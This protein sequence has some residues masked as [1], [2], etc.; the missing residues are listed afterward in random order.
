MCG[1]EAYADASIGSLGIEFRKRVT[2]GVELA[3]K[4]TLLLFLDEPTS[5][6]DSQ[7]A[8]A[9]MAFLRNLANNGQAILCTIH[10][11]SAD[12]FQVFDRLLLLRK[13]GQTV[14]FGDLGHNA[15]TLIHYFEKNGAR[16][17]EPTENPA[18]FMLDVIGAGATATSEQDWHAIWKRSSEAVETQEEL[19]SIHKDGRSRPPVEA[20]IHS[21]FATPWVHQ[22]KELCFRD[23]R[24][25]WRS[26]TYLMAKL[27]LNIF[28]GLFIGFTFFKAKN[29][30]QGTQ[31]QLFAV[32]MATILSAPLS[33]QLM[34]P[35][36]E[37]RKIYEIRER[38]SRMFS[39][40]ALVTSQFLADLPW[41][42]L[43]SSI[44]FLCWYW[45]VAFDT[46]RAGF[47]YL[48]LGV[49]F[50]LY[51]T[52]LAMGVAAMAP[53]AEISALLFSVLF[54]FI[55]TFNGVL[56]PFRELGWWKW[57][58][59]V[60]PYTY[61][62]EALLGQAL[63]HH[64]IRCSPV[65]LVTLTPPSGQTCGSYL[66]TYISHAGGYVTNPSATSACE[67]CAFATTDQFLENNFNIF[68]S[69]HWR[70]FGIMIGYIIFNIAAIYLLTYWFRIRTGSILGSL[71]ARLSR[72]S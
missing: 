31:N 7:S 37:M 58:Y 43:G 20:T 71:K 69:N 32:Y 54:S 4:P 44:F 48:M 23:T 67:F 33:N 50:P 29:T 57:M 1:L 2:I 28:G 8:W 14:Y 41:N 52:S 56:Q 64:A 26:P 42:I 62:I 45:T 22:L 25:H 53:S 51:Y 27:V 17:C 34:V 39:W 61:L 60:S 49:T 24:A 59:H 19:E 66:D 30:Q 70:D 11:P 68:Y 47:T 10:Q 35:F 6:L 72:K 13:G 40:T 12:L 9:I 55:L 38:P 15:T 46:S 63:G 16:H 36:L 65:E 3:A 21:E 18:E 5:G